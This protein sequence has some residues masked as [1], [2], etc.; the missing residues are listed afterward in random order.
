MTLYTD[1]EKD[2]QVAM[3][4]VQKTGRDFQVQH[5]F[6]LLCN[7]IDER[8]EK[9]NCNH[10]YICTDPRGCRKKHYECKLCNHTIK[11]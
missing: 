7:L 1:L 5:I 2:I 8:L 11:I 4:E 10:E 9:L 6:A 3:E